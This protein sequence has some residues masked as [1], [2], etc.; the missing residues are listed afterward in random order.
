MTFP[1][2]RTLLATAFAVVMTGWALGALQYNAVAGVTLAPDAVSE[3]LDVP[4]VA[5]PP[6]PVPRPRRRQA[7]RLM[8]MLP[9][10]KAVAGGD[11]ATPPPPRNELKLLASTS[12]AL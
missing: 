1:G 8:D 10:S 6:A 12:C 5:A 2:R 4:A 7:P 9:V 11:K 3:D